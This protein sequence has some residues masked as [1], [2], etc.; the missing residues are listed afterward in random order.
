MTAEFALFLACAALVLL[1]YL[2]GIRMFRMRVAEM[3]QNR[4]H[5]Q[6]IALSAERSSKL[7]DTRASDNFN[8]LFELPTLFYALCALAIALGHVPTWLV[9]AAWVF[10]TS[11]LVHSIIQC[12]SNKV[13]HRFRLFLLG[14]FLLLGMWGAYIPSYLLALS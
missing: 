3:K 8:H 1:T 9:V 5:P 6:T 14:S 10:V 4:V 7:A 11:R 12:G 13:M 2:V